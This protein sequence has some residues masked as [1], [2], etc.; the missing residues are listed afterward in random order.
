M[1]TI[2]GL[3]RKKRRKT[4]GGKALVK[5]L[6][7]GGVLPDIIL[8]VVLETIVLVVPAVVIVT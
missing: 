3:K 1:F 5:A 6:M 7:D 2:T 4:R 8:P